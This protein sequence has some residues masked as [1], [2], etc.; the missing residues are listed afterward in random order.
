M[1]LDPHRLSATESPDRITRPDPE[2]FQAALGHVEDQYGSG[3]LAASAARGLV[4]SIVETLGAFVGDPDLPEH[5]RSGYQGLLESA[6]ELR[7]KIGE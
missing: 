4:Y 6:R 1:T 5:V 3:H 7:A 2:H